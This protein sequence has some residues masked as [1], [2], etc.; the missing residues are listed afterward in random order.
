MY[1]Y[2]LAVAWAFILKCLLIREL[3]SYI[4]A[5]LSWPDKETDMMGVDKQLNNCIIIITV[6]ASS[7]SRQLC[8]VQQAGAGV[9]VMNTLHAK[10]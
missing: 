6:G 5:A 4:V 10:V 1:V 7:N 8:N 3:F 9:P 2:N